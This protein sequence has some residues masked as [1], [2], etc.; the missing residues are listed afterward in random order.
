M[1]YIKKINYSFVFALI[2]VLISLLYNFQGML[3]KAPYSIHQ[4]RQC[5]GMSIT[6]NYY[7]EGMKFF[8]PSMHFQ[9][10]NEGK[11]IGEFP[12][13]YY[14]NAAIWKITGQSNITAR[15]L[16][17]FI[18]F[19]GLF[20]LYKTVY[21]LLKDYFYSIIIPLLVFSS[22]LYS[23]YLSGFL[24][25]V[26]AIS[27]IFISWYFIA[28]Y[29]KNKR[30]LDLALFSL[31]VTIAGVL[32]STVLLGMAPFLL[33]YALEFLGIIKAKLFDK[34]LA[35]FIAL[36]FPIVV[37][38]VWLKFAINYNEA[39]N[40]VYFLTKLR[41]IWAA[42]SIEIARIFSSLYNNLLPELFH[43]SV[44]VFLSIVL[45]LGFIFIGKQN[46]Y[47][48]II[49]ITILIELIVYLLLWFLNL[50]VHDYYLLEIIILVPPLLLSVAMALKDRYTKLFD[51]L[52]LRYF[53]AFIL[54]VSIAYTSFSLRAKYRGVGDK[55]IANYILDK[56][57]IAYWNWYHWH[58]SN[59]FKAYESITPYLRSIGI[60]REDLVLSI[61]DQSPNISLY[62]M[63]QKGFSSLYQEDKSIKEQIDFYTKR[64]IKYIIVNDA[65]LMQGVEL[66]EYKD[67]KIGEYKNIVIYKL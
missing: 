12:I 54:L 27:F 32:R 49:W 16:N 28:K 7:N 56:K 10:S 64:G 47:L 48:A 62:L 31:S 29:W 55:N 18:A 3:N 8:Q 44:E 15:L 53:I 21:L 13:I 4:W 2:V 1:H 63:D 9:Y 66:E 38:A 59:T 39:N 24:V 46:K 58:Y 33:I 37:L 17:I 14:I 52:F 19:M 50:D 43:Y 57:D 35:S 30:I 22:T 41:P 5:D 23:Y 6:L 42:D 51:L 67:N 11:G 26:D 34:K 20:A 36:L 40:S 45:F 61:K 65:S 60:N 25:N